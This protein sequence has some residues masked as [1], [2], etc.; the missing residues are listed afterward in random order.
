MAFAAGI[1]VSD[2]TDDSDTFVDA[3]S[4]AIPV[5]MGVSP[6]VARADSVITADAGSFAVATG[7]GV[8]VAASR[9]D[10]FNLN[11]LRINAPETTATHRTAVMPQ[12]KCREPFV[13]SGSPCFR[14]G[15]RYGENRSSNSSV[16]SGTPEI[17]NS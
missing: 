12:M 11:P 14:S 9:S 3:A 15:F 8:S 2:D 17:A 1:S 7:M 10:A 4:S 5:G 16:A 6:T 13:V